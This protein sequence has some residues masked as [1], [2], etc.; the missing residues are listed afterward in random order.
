MEVMMIEIDGSVGEGGGQV[1]RTAIALSAVTGKPCRVF[2]I[3]K[4]RPNPGLKAQH[5][6]AI[7]AVQHLCNARV[8]GL[9]IGSTEITFTPEKI[10]SGEININ[11]QTAGSIG[12]VLQAVMIPAMHAP[13]P[14]KIKSSGGATNGRWAPPLNY[15]KYVL[16]PLLEKMGYSM[17]LEIKRYGY[18]PKGGAVVDAVIEPR[19]LF[20]LD[21]TEKGE[22]L[23][24]TGT[25]HASESLRKARVAERQKDAAV[26][27][28]KEKTGVAPDISV[29][30]SDTACPGSGIE[31]QAVF[32]NSVIGADALGEKNIK[33]EDVGKQAAEKLLEAINSSACVDEHAEDQLLPYM[34]LAPPSQI[35]VPKITG[36]TRTNIWV[37]EKFLPVKFEV[38][39]KG[40]I[41]SVA[42]IN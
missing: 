37:I 38:D 42:P 41:I 12:L 24:I 1:I 22:L 2:N 18:F 28:L 39:E 20:S 17:S 16:L 14:V 19:K 3:R 6:E 8:S 13:A 23:S 29:I 33:A 40:G 26:Q 21:L 25:S 11:I 36:H 34:V 31:L 27:R 10:K 7:K 5:M 32:G 9:S 15:I 30:Y 4:G 35:K